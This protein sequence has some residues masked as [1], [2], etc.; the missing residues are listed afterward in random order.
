MATTAGDGMRARALVLQNRFGGFSLVETMLVLGVM[1]ILVALAVPSFHGLIQ[2]LRITTAAN[3]LFAAINLTR[4][5][6]IKRGARV[7]LTTTDPQSDWEHGW[8]VF[9]DKNGTRKPDTGDEIIFER[10]PVGGGI[11]IKPNLNGS[12]LKYLAYNGTGRTRTNENGQTP[13][14]GNF[15]FIIGGEVKRKIVV[16][17]LGRARV[18]TPAPDDGDC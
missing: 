9:I 8:V 6:A 3:E 18:C 4:S 14:L 5:E 12:E 17:F 15:S 11:S 13:L 10:G 7:D 16:S 2:N 1:A